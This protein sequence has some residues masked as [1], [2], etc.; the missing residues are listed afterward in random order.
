MHHFS[1]SIPGEEK[2]LYELFP[3]R[4]MGSCCVGSAPCPTS[5]CY[6]RQKNRGRV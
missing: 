2:N 4:L 6:R 1:A 5:E 3:N